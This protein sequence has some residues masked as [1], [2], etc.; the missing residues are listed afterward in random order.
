[1]PVPTS[2]TLDWILLLSIALLPSNLPGRRRPPR[3]PLAKDLLQG[4]GALRA[5]LNQAAHTILNYL[6]AST[7]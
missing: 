7:L 2:A 3:R 6:P 4:G 5:R 1:M